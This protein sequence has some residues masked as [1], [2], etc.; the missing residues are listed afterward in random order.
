MPKKAAAI[1]T[2]ARVPNGANAVVMMEHAG[3]WGT[4]QFR[5]SRSRMW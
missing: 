4:I 3:V 1:A 5:F 2:G